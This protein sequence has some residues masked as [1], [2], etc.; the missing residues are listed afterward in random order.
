MRQ[1]T[2]RHPC[3]SRVIRGPL[4]VARHEATKESEMELALHPD[5]A[6]RF[7]EL[8]EE[9]LLKLVVQPAA[10]KRKRMANILAHCSIAFD[11]GQ[12]RAVCDAARRGGDMDS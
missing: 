2:P 8:G 12:R 5:A 7:D 9:L 6:R 1:D 3:R 10:E 11:L 4:E